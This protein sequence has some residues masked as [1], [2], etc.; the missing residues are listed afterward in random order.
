[1]SIQNLTSI[2]I[3]FG[4]DDEIKTRS[5]WK[6]KRKKAHTQR[7]SFLT[8][9]FP[10]LPAKADQETLNQVPQ[11]EEAWCPLESLSSKGIK[12]IENGKY[13]GKF[14]FFHLFVLGR[15]L[16]IWKIPG[17]ELKQSTGSLTHS[18]RPGI[19]PLFSGTPVR[20]MTAEPRRELPG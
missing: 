15:T 2:D 6:E 7:I 13:V 18:A 3:P 8:H 10:T 12:T 19:E 9:P 17:Q 4:K 20:F 11:A 14:F 5:D 16:G 1:M